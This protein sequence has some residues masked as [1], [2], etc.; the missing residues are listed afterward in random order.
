MTTDRRALAFALAA[1]ALIDGPRPAAAAD[2]L[3][4]ISAFAPGERGGIH[5]Y[6]LSI[7]D[8]RLK[9]LRRTAGVRLCCRIAG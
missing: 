9:P 5:A 1:L 8:G 4:F 3:V 2:P 6:E 7:K